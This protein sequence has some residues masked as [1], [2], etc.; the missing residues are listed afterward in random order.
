MSIVIF[1][2]IKCKKCAFSPSSQIKP[3]TSSDTAWITRVET[4]IYFVVD[5]IPYV[6][7]TRQKSCIQSYENGE[8]WKKLN[9]DRPVLNTYF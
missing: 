8:R 3:P 9:Y 5:V 2:R 6:S 1:S 4:L 7:R